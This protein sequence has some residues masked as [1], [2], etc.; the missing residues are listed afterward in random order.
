MI[1]KLKFGFW[2]HVPTRIYSK[3]RYVRK[4]GVL[5]TL[6]FKLGLSTMQEENVM[7]E[8]Q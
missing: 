2:D 1:G 5:N 8:D 6:N 7:E 3:I 4:M